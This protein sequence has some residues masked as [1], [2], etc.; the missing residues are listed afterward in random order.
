MKFSRMPENRGGGKLPL[1]G[2]FVIAVLAVGALISYVATGFGSDS[3]QTSQLA[4]P[5]GITK[6][7]LTASQGVRAF[8]QPS[9]PTL[10]PTPLPTAGLRLLDSDP[11]PVAGVVPD[12]RYGEV[13]AEGFVTLELPGGT[14]TATWYTFQVDTYSKDITLFFALYDSTMDTI[15]KTVEVQDYAQS[16]II[17]N[18]EITMFYPDGPERLLK[19]D[20]VEGTVSLAQR[21]GQ[22]YGPS[23]F[24]PELRVSLVNYGLQMT[25]GI[26][27]VRANVQ[28]DLSGLSDSESIAL[29]QSNPTVVNKVMLELQELID[30]IE[31]KR[32][33]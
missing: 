3:P 16:A 8:P 27:S 7:S 13:L 12:V 14:D 26:G 15:I 32:V 11:G 21:Y 19:F 5:Q 23:L 9:A 30:Q 29:I 6:T 2:I 25:D 20:A 31:R 18:A 28:L 10:S 4:P 22:P 1:I 17:N 33:K 24:S